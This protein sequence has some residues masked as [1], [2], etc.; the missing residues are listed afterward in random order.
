MRK[1]TFVAIGL[2]AGTQLA[3]AQSS[4]TVYG[5]LGGGIRNTPNLAVS[6]DNVTSVDDGMRSR[7]GFRGKEDLGGGLSAFFRLESSLRMDTGAQRDPAKFFDDK[8]W[9]GLEHVKF[10][11]VMTGR[12]RTSV[13]EMI[14]G[15]RF[16]AFEGYTLGAAGGRNGRADDAWDNAVYYTT[17]KFNNFRAGGGFRL[18]EGTV[19]NSRGV[20][21]EYTAAPLDIGLAYQVDSESLTS[22]KRSFGGGASYKFTGFSLYGTYVKTTDVGATDSGSA[23]TGTIGIRVPVGPGEFRAAA[24]K[25][26]NDL[27]ASS[28]SY[29]SDVDT[30]QYS[31]GYHYPLSKRTS[32]NASLIRMS[33]KTYDAA[34][35]VLTNRSGTGSE[36]AFRVAF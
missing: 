9:V 14:S 2:L 27:I 35:G 6:E 1:H 5:I 22:T 4:V 28:T 11:S 13:D 32:V 7:F 31:I 33:R 21:L 24:R 25:V 8:A 10:G 18:G 29:A 15:S 26:D 34:G 30:T 19:G 3:I 17:P 20:H 12:L 36:L 23:Y 16:E